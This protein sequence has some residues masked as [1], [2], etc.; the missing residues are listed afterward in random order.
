MVMV[1]SDYEGEGE[2]PTPTPKPVLLQVFTA[3]QKL[4]EIKREIVFR[5]RVYARMVETGSMKASD[6]EYRIAVMEQIARDYQGPAPPRF[7]FGASS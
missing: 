3:A 2:L 1:G 6:A 5:R 7:D 4:A